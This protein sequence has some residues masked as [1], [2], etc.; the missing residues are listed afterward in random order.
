MII[1]AILISRG[2]NLANELALVDSTPQDFFGR[3]L[4]WFWFWFGFGLV[5]ILVQ[6]GLGGGGLKW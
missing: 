4:V 2:L 3:G 1:C 6:F 5:L